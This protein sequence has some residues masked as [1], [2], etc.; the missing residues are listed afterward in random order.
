MRRMIASLTA[1]ALLAAPIGV[2]AQELPTTPPPIPAPKAFTV[3]ASETYVL[4]NGM[5]V[6]LIPYG[7]VPKAVVSLQTYTGS[8]NEGPDT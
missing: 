2:A 8:I 4:A 6:T 7:V 5:R 3:P 1:A